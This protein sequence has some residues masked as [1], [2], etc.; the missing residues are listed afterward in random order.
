KP[1]PESY[2]H[3]TRNTRLKDMTLGDLN[4]QITAIRTGERRLGQ[5]LDRIGAD[6]YRAACANIFEQ[7]QLLDRQAIGA[8]RDGT[9]S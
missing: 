2:E 9:Y 3:L 6:V 8:L 4:A 7:A 5:V 1:I